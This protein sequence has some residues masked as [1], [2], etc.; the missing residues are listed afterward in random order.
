MVGL[1]YGDDAL[2]RELDWA[3]RGWSEV[4][5]PVMS[6]LSYSWPNGYMLACLTGTNGIGDMGF[7]GN[8]STKRKICIDLHY[9]TTA[10]THPLSGVGVR[11]RRSLTG[12]KPLMFFAN[13]NDHRKEFIITTN[14][15]N[16]S[17]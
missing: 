13:R 15:A 16:P 11:F 1:V 4:E 9:P 2:H 14:S 7:F 5:G 10:C 17:P 12:L 8:P 3:R 6:D